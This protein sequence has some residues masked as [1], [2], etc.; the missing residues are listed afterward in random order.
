MPGLRQQQQALRLCERTTNRPAV[1]QDRQTLC[2]TTSP[3]KDRRSDAVGGVLNTMK[4]KRVLP[5]QEAKERQLSTLWY[6]L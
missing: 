5:I 6:L 3:W 1:D 4:G 2:V